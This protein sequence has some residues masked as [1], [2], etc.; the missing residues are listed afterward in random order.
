VLSTLEP[1]DIQPKAELPRARQARAILD[2][3]PEGRALARRL[4][5]RYALVSPTCPD[6]REG[7][8]EPRRA[9]TRVFVS[10][11]LVILRL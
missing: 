1:E 5:V 6:L 9:G 7:E 8:T 11:Q 10:E 2:A 4:G 3:T